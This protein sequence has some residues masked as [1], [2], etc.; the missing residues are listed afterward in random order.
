M[1]SIS[2]L[3]TLENEFVFGVTGLSQGYVS[4]PVRS[5]GGIA[6]LAHD[7]LMGEVC[8]ARLPHQKIV[9]WISNAQQVQI[10]CNRDCLRAG[11][12]PF[13][14]EKLPKRQIDVNQM[15]TGVNLSHQVHLDII[16]MTN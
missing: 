5:T 4:E 3:S 9:S 7:F 1:R 15:A 16:A 8:G 6:D 13:A 14:S 10:G 12:L 2:T 11:A